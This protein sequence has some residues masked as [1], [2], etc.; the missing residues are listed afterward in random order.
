M[1]A[2]PLIS[3]VVCTFNRSAYL[4]KAIR[5]L[6]EQTLDSRLYEVCV[7]D[8]CSTD[9]TRSVVAEESAG[10]ANVRYI[11][12]PLQG[13]SRARNTGWQKAQGKYIAY[14]DDD[15]TA[16]PQWLEEIVRA[17]ETVS[18]MPGA[19]GGRIDPIWEA[20]RPSWLSDKVA[21]GLTI[22][23]WSETPFF[24]RDDQWL[25]GANVAYPAALLKT[26]GGFDVS[27][28]RSGSNLISCEEALLN[29]R[30]T[31]LGHPLYY[32]PSV[33]VRHHIAASRLTKKWHIRRQYWNGI[34]VAFA[35]RRQTPLPFAQRGRRAMAALGRDGLAQT[36]ELLKRR[37]S[38]REDER[39]EL[40]C[41]VIF[42]LG[43]SVGLLAPLP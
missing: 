17:F 20:P 10:A 42:N 16:S 8:N 1:S 34:S 19:V 26:T 28:G 25:A 24:I 29:N 2:S 4:R 7:V 41:G 22:L 33:A 6:R 30:L 40:Q 3:A 23:D 12:E 35:L 11:Y 27:L 15:A 38:L 32:H 37:N 9:D 43:Y 18:P 14:L 31:G 21:L 36:T 39:F 5:S 13:L